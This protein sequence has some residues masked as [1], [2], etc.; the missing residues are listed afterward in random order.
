MSMNNWIPN[1]HQSAILEVAVAARTRRRALGLSQTEVGLLAG[2]GKR[3]VVEFEQGKPSV[4]MEKVVAVLDA[5]GLQLSVQ[6]REAYH[7]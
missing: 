1:A 2:C 3:F 5:L 7:P 6:P 4:R